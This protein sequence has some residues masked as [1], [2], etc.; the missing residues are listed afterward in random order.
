MEVCHCFRDCADAYKM[1][2]KNTPVY[3]HSSFTGLVGV[4]QVDIT[5]PT[6]IY[7]GNWGAAKGYTTKGV[8]RP[9]LLTCLTFQCSKQEKPLV[10][11]AADL[12]WWKNQ[13]DERFLRNGIL[14]ALSLDPSQLMFCLSHTHAGPGLCRNDV[15]KPGGEYIEQYLYDIQQAAIHTIHTALSNAIPA[16]LNWHYGKCNL[17][18]NRD[19]ANTRKDRFVV[20]FNPG[21]KADDTLLVG[22]ITNQQGKIISTIVNYACHPTTLGWDNLFISPDY[23]GAMREIIESSTHAPCLFLQG[24]SGELAPAEQYTGDTSVA[25]KHGC[26]LGYA[27]LSVLE[28]MLPANMDLSF[29]RIVESGAS[30]GVWKRTDSHPSKTL[31]GKI[32]QVQLPL[33]KL[34]SLEETEKH[35]RACEDP[36]LKERLWRKLNIR[37]AVGDDEVANIPLWIWRLGDSLLISQPNEAYS[38]FQ[39]ELRKEFPGNAVAVMNVVNGHIGYLP[40]AHLYDKDIY[41]VWQTPFAKGSLEKLIQTSINTSQQMMNEK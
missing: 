20:G 12:G 22:R 17:A 6:G 9:L 28:S 38:L 33:K 2:T 40:P 24:A 10:L 32:I 27:A 29:D 11:I 25:D 5:P 1:K 26:Q 41:P 8:H 14:N 3:K 34:L 35:W 23:I 7:L 37:K 15:S 16:T 18:A 19:L 4:A 39:Q 13:E 31:L 21:E 36:V 30:L